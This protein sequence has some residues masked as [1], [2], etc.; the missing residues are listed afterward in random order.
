[1]TEIAALQIMAMAAAGVAQDFSTPLN[2]TTG[3]TCYTT[4]HGQ[5][6]R[7]PSRVDEGERFV[8]LNGPAPH[9]HPGREAPSDSRQLLARAHRCTWRVLSRVELS[10][11]WFVAH[12]PEAYLTVVDN[13]DE[14]VYTD[15]STLDGLSVSA[16]STIE[17]TMDSNPYSYFF[18]ICSSSSLWDSGCNSVL[19]TS[20]APTNPP[21]QSPTSWPTSASPTHEEHHSTT[22]FPVSAIVLVSAFGGLI[23]VSSC[24]LGAAWLRKAKRR[25]TGNPKTRRG[26]EDEDENVLLS[27]VAS[28]WFHQV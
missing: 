6:I 3:S 7:A 20:P 16:G 22:G 2:V 4:A 14:H 25:P 23:V 28:N 5:C 11:Q 8:A 19:S 1:V 24:A 18:C 27:D 15:F 10:A 13:G 9:H 21:T 17:W 12:L 26:Y